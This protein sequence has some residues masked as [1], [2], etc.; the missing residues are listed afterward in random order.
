MT[1]FCVE[2]GAKQL[3]MPQRVL[4][5]KMSYAIETHP[6]IGPFSFSLFRFL[7]V[8]ALHLLFPFGKLPLRLLSFILFPYRFVS[9]VDPGAE[10]L[11]CRFRLNHNKQRKCIF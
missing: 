5:A 9:L 7:V 6:Y 8:H 11:Y 1:G 10:S 2:N 3:K 4:S